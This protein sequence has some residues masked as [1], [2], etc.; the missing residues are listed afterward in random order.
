M[1]YKYNL[2]FL[3]VY[4]LLTFFVAI[5]RDVRVWEDI[6]SEPSVYAVGA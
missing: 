5:V 4:L 6:F 2:R 3:N 1:D